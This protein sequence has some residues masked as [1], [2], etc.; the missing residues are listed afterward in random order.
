[1]TL[2]VIGQKLLT[3]YTSSSIKE[4]QNRQEKKQILSRPNHITLKMNATNLYTFGLFEFLTIRLPVLIESA[5]Y[6]ASLSSYIQVLCDLNTT[7][8][9][10]SADSIHLIGCGLNTISTSTLESIHLIGCGLN[11]IGTNAVDST[12]FIGW[13]VDTISDDFIHLNGCGLNIISSD[14]VHLIWF[15]PPRYLNKNNS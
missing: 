13:G 2:K 3:T 8:T 14:S 10:I 15:Q 9:M 11:T 6:I 4:K 12:Y 1:M 5:E 7:T